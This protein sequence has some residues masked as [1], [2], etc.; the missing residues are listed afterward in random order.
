MSRPRTLA[1]RLTLSGLALALTTTL[2]AQVTGERRTLTLDDALGLV[3]VTSE[4]VAIAEA[5]LARS[6]A[7]EARVRSEL[8]PQLSASAS[9]DRTLASEFSGL[10]DSTGPACTPLA[11]DPS[12]S[13]ADRVGEIERA[14]RDCPPS[15]SPFGGATLPFGRPNIYR[16]NLSFSQNLYSGGRIQAQRAQARLSTRNASLT[17][18]SA[19]AQAALDVAQAFYDAALSDRLV[20]IQEATVAQADSTYGQVRQQREAGRQSE[21][22]LL[23]AQ[24]ARDTLQPE[25]FRR[26]GQRDVAHLRLKQLLEIPGGT[27]LE[28][29]ANLEGDELPTSPALAPALADAEAA[30]SVRPRTAVD[31]LRLDVQSRESAITVVRAQRKPTVAV[32]SAYG[33]V[34]YPS[35]APSFGD[36]R[37]NWT[38]GASVSVP[39][40]TGGRLEAE[41]ASARADLTEAQARLKRTQELVVLDEESARR[42]LEAARAAW[43]ATGGT[44]RQAQRAYEIAELRYREGLSTQLEISDARLL[45]QQAQVNRAQAARD[46][47]VARVRFALLPNLP[48]GAGAASPASAAAGSPAAAGR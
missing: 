42:D 20:S 28:L 36:W 22:D 8:L 3:D 45:L 30:A 25:L 23:R 46:F 2:D 6:R 14:L 4:D 5:G 38:V 40:L 32:S 10:F 44:I 39:V 11:I 43:D 19:K 15:S 29:V 31:A 26:R 21:F 7:G 18:T 27:V 13:L 9:Y 37:T 17:L 33:N 41:E 16:L 47:Q 35:V 34:A 24:V 1:R 12:A 48:V